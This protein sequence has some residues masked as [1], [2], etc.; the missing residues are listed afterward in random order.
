MCS[1]AQAARCVV[2]MANPDTQTG[3]RPSGGHINVTIFQYLYIKRRNYGQVSQT[4]Q[5][6]K[7]MPI[8]RVSSDDGW[9]KCRW[10]RIKN[11]SRVRSAPSSANVRDKKRTQK[12]SSTAKID[13]GAGLQ[14]VRDLVQGENS[15]RSPTLPAPP[16]YITEP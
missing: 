8:K 1:L 16:S 12:F 7:I 11:T 15:L 4:K 10:K 6:R 14:T 2:C 13:K 3:R 5:K 9:P